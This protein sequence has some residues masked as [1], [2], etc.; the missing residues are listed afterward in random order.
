MEAHLI[1]IIRF[2]ICM[3]SLVT[4]AAVMI[5]ADDNNVL[6]RIAPVTAAVP[7]CFNMQIGEVVY[8]ILCAIL[9]AFLASMGLLFI[10]LAGFAVAI[11]PVIIIW[12]WLFGK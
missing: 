9:E 11:A 2:V 7:I 10:V 12:R 1:D 4:A 5:R 3:L 8:Q 6:R